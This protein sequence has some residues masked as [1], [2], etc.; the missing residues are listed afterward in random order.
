MICRFLFNC[1]GYGRKA[2][3]SQLRAASIAEA[4]IT[5]AVLGIVLSLAGQI[6]VHSFRCSRQSLD[7]QQCWRDAAAVNDRLARELRRCEAIVWPVYTDWTEGR[8]ITAAKGKNLLLACRLAAAGQDDGIVIGYRYL[9]KKGLLER[10]VYPASFKFTTSSLTSDKGIL[11][12]QILLRGVT[13]FS[14]W[15]APVKKCCGKNMLGFG[16]TVM[17]VPQ[18][19]SYSQA[20][21]QCGMSLCTEVRIRRL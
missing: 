19:K 8:E 16:L 18:N 21:A 7:G 1:R 15:S 2:P 10:C 9:G 4:L 14:F 20:Y 17:P 13:G 12:R 11:S 6:A 5:M 3:R